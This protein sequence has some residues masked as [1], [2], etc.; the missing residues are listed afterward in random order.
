[1]KTSALQQI[2]EVEPRPRL[3]AVSSAVV[4]RDLRREYD[5]REVVR[6]VSLEVR[7]GE[8]FGLL[9]PNGAGK[10][11][12]L[13]MIS[14]RL[15]PTSGDV[16]VYGK[17]VVHDLDAARRLLNVAPQEEALYRTLTAAENLAFFAELYGVPRAQR[18]RAVADTLDVVGLTGRKD[19]R[20][21]T[22]SGGM[23]RRLNLGCALVSGPRV[24]LLDEPT[25]AVD[26]QSRAHI[27]DAVRALRA[28]GTTIL[29]TTHHLQ[30]AEG[31]CDRIAI[32]DE[33][34]VVASGTLPELLAL[35]RTTEVVELRL[36]EALQTTAPL[37]ALDG[38]RGVEVVGPEL[39]ISTSRAQQV[40]PRLYRAVSAL[41]HSVV[42]TRVTPVT[43]DDVF[44]ELTGKELRD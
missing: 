31:L 1:M 28:R 43:L 8:I 38:V 30:E 19:D 24:V 6:G 26:P 9:G 3:R 20:V 7:E 13:S 37:R 44:L 21:D 35:S 2:V 39:R 5:G 27:F 17:H 36:R 18:R 25:V 4:L 42:R 41:G 34:R 16:W 11:T 14:T 40:L 10:T 12:L 29:Y 33:G 15:R 22:Y 32:M 23:R